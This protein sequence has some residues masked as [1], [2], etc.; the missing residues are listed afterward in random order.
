ME[1]DAVNEFD[2][3]EIKQILRE[4]LSLKL[5]EKR[6]I[7][8]RNKLNVALSD[9]LCQF[10]A[11]YKLMGFDLDG[12]PISMTVYNNKMEKNALDCQFM[13]EFSGFMVNKHR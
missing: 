8:R 10:L 3:E 7:P 6:A 13:E 12:N 1:N 2:D 11:C 9:T 4:A 5:A